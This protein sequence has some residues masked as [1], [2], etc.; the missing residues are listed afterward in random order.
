MFVNRRKVRI[1]WGDCDP[2]GIVYYPRYFAMF[3]HSTAMLL[4]AATGYTKYQMRE[5]YD[6]VGFPMVDTGAKFMIP[7]KFGDD[8]VIESTI[9]E[10]GKSSFNILHK[11]WKGDH[12]AIE[13]HEKR[14][15]VGPH[16]DDATKIKSKPI[17][18]EVANKLRGKTTI[19]V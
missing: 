10:L 16:P 18:D 6:F 3:D 2:A 7:S 11:V 19:E 13:A 17:P 12:L 9:S 4:E 1:E 8:I 5:V 14:V 15:W